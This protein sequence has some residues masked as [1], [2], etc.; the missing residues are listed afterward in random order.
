MFPQRLTEVVLKSIL[1]ILMTK[2]QIKQT[3]EI[4]ILF[5][6]SNGFIVFKKTPKWDI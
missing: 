2:I 5:K 6:C 1:T 4:C 3:F